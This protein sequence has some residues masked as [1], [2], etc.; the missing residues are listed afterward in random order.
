M[1]EVYIRAFIH[2][3]GLVRTFKELES[4]VSLVWLTGALL[5]FFSFIPF[6]A[7]KE[8]IRVLGKEKVWELFLYKY[9][10]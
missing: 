9:T 8:L 6:F 3:L 7:F 10:E 4:H 5:I 1:A 2:N